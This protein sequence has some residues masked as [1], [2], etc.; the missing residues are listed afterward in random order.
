MKKNNQETRNASVGVFSLIVW[1]VIIG[2]LLAAW[3][4]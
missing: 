2:I 1:A 4:L 3:Y